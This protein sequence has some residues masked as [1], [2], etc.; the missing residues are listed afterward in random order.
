[1][2][3]YFNRAYHYHRYVT[4]H[5]GGAKENR[6]KGAAKPEWKKLRLYS[7]G[8]SQ[9]TGLVL[10]APEGLR[11]CPTHGRSCRCH[12]GS[13]MC[14]PHTAEQRC[15]TKILTQ[16]SLPGYYKVKG[17]GRV[18]DMVGRGAGWP[19]NGFGMLAFFDRRLLGRP[20]DGERF[21]TN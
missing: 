6:S 9:L 5:H 8:R 15:G 12:H 19:R 20:K 16:D 7:P 3:K 4:I 10:A 1:M 18:E 17:V 14:G 13:A 2:R 11:L 21:A